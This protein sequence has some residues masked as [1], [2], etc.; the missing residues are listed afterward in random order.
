MFANL[1]KHR[2]VRPDQVIGPKW[3][4]KK[5]VEAQ[6]FN[7]KKIKK[8]EQLFKQ[9]E[10]LFHTALCYDSPYP[11]KKLVTAI[12]SLE[13]ATNKNELFGDGAGELIT[14]TLDIMFAVI[15]EEYMLPK[16]KK[17]ILKGRDSQCAEKFAAE[18]T[19]VFM[20]F[21][22]ELKDENPEFDLVRMGGRNAGEKGL[23]H[24]VKKLFLKSQDSRETITQVLYPRFRKICSAYI[25]DLIIRMFIEENT[26]FKYIE[27]R[28]NKADPNKFYA[29]SDGLVEKM[30][31]E[32]NSYLQDIVAP[33][34][35]LGM[36]ELL[37]ESMR[38]I[39]TLFVEAQIKLAPASA[40]VTDNNN[41][42]HGKGVLVTLKNGQ[43]ITVDGAMASSIVAFATII[44]MG[45][46]YLDW[47]DQ[48]KANLRK[49]ELEKFIFPD[50]EGEV[51]QRSLK[52]MLLDPDFYVPVLCGQSIDLFKNPSDE[53]F[54]N[55]LG[56]EIQFVQAN[57]K[58]EADKRLKE[59]LIEL[60]N[61]HEA[62]L[63]SLKQIKSGI[64]LKKWAPQAI[65]QQLKNN[66]T[67]DASKSLINELEKLLENYQNDLD[68]LNTLEWQEDKPDSLKAKLRPYLNFCK[69]NITSQKKEETYEEL[70]NFSKDIE[71]KSGNDFEEFKGKLIEFET[72]VL[73]RQ[74]SYKM[75]KF[76]KE[77]F[78]EL[79][80][81]LVA[82]KG[83][84]FKAVYAK[85]I[86]MVFYQKIET[87]EKLAKSENEKVCVSNLKR[88]LERYED[89]AFTLREFGNDYRDTIDNFRYKKVAEKIRRFLSSNSLLDL[90][91]GLAK[92]EFSDNNEIRIKEINIIAKALVSNDKKPLKDL[93][94][95]NFASL[96]K[97][98]LEQWGADLKS[99]LRDN[100]GILML[101]FA[102]NRFG[103]RKRIAAE[104]GEQFKLPFSADELP[105]VLGT[106]A[107]LSD[108][109]LVN[110][111]KFQ[112]ESSKT[113]EALKAEKINQILS[114]TESPL[115]DSLEAFLSAEEF[116]FYPLQSY[117]ELDDKSKGIN[118]AIKDWLKFMEGIGHL[119]DKN[120][121]FKTVY[122]Q[123]G[124][125]FQA[126]IAA[127]ASH[128]EIYSKF[129]LFIT[130]VHFLIHQDELAKVPIRNE[131]IQSN[132]QNL[133]AVVLDNPARSAAAALK[134]PN[135]KPEPPS[136]N[137]PPKKR[138][139]RATK[140]MGTGA[141][142]K[143]FLD[144]INA[145]GDKGKEE[146]DVEYL[147][148]T[149][150]LHVGLVDWD[151]IT[152]DDMERKIIFSPRKK[153]QIY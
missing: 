97:S 68:A 27:A 80:D 106:M 11:L 84:L 132:T 120:N 28:V 17:R 53:N 34:C 64:F 69:M 67:T 44:G 66:F 143:F 9:L 70:W 94:D 138:L 142:L 86:W 42:N 59:D 49:L 74:F 10:D 135:Y 116:L 83:E 21:A 99:L 15:D 108:K 87:A 58:T 126:Q 147:K 76:E 46:V 145:N 128:K 39:F 134:D 95:K 51:L 109:S 26:K 100:I 121:D 7:L 113:K 43:T 48:L 123:S 37:P 65:I 82:F 118:E 57:V 36:Q 90:S 77:F 92:F 23:I 107:S 12:T 75:K 131:L 88:L 13:T 35:E 153:M 91:R 89:K 101:R 149:S 33:R 115:I 1:Q 141:T 4:Y 152:A 47:I 38:N 98:F 56:Q 102:A 146:V 110:I 122:N 140:A 18:L 119:I 22:E 105:S 54:K 45:S 16:N 79:G 8:P 19:S 60:L 55:K 41:V 29:I 3:V 5:I 63:E 30:I 144:K 32:A 127:I 114:D 25:S 125:T 78:K 71:K 104:L 150:S 148:A 130:Y 151:K 72:K 112:A 85:K 50:D 117:L 133:I 73:K 2:I 20:R 129:Y 40:N 96:L 137:D 103:F 93:T 6:Y 14:K 52:E 111:F 24:V 61:T 31:W 139:F 136:A 81:R 124:K 62:K